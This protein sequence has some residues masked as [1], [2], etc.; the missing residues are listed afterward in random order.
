VLRIGVVADTHLPR[1]G[2]ALP[3]ALV[4]GLRDAAVERILHLGDWT[5]PLAVTLLEELAPVD[6]V[7]GNNDPPTLV[8]RFGM[9][10]VVRLVGVR[11]G[12]T[13]GHLGADR[14]TPERAREVFAHER[15]LGAI[16][17]GHSHIPMIAAPAVAGEPWLIN[18]GSPT[19]KRRQPR[20]TWA[21][22]TL[23]AGRVATVE[24]RAYDDRTP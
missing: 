16:L 14:S 18:P 15:D 5:D 3:R 20:Y 23:H 6:G 7:A 11:V 4:A 2:R 22:V 13:H 9:V 24:L 8:E 21:L 10:K 12:L 19:D 17:F 1:F